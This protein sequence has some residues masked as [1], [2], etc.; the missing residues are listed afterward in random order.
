VGGHTVVLVLDCPP[1]MDDGGWQ[2]GMIIDDQASDEQ[3]GALGRVIG[4]EAGGP[5]AAL[6]PLIG[7][8][9]GVERMPITFVDDGKRHSVK[10]GNAV[11]I[12]I[13]IE[14]VQQAEGAPSVG[15]TGIVFHPFGPDLSISKANRA[16]V[17]AFGKKWDNAGKNGHPTA[18][19][20][21]E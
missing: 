21:A 10:A 19:S 17:D 16:T 1:Q 9:L 3:A 5:M 12:E 14:E 15:L 11:D 8:M 20:W 6:T 2:L 13:E 7:E 18:F 4:G